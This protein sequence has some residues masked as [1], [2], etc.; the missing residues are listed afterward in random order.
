MSLLFGKAL[1]NVITIIKEKNI[2]SIKST[3]F[4]KELGLVAIMYILMYLVFFQTATQILRET[5]FSFFRLDNEA[6]LA[7][8]FVCTGVLALYPIDFHG[9]VTF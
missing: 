7:A 9:I 2:F 4:I 6:R 5:I 1:Q 8:V 3:F